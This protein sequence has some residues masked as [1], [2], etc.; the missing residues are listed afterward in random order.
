MNIKKLLQITNK[1]EDLSTLKV[2]VSL[3]KEENIECDDMII[4]DIDP[5]FQWINNNLQV[6]F[7]YEN[8]LH[9]D[10]IKLD[11]EDME[12]VVSHLGD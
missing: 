1:T 3:Q 10:Y 2:K 6:K 9:G 7:K 8:N 4:G 11:S 12:I 5:N